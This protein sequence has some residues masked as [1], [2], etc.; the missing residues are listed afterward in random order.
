MPDG[1]IESSTSSQVSFVNRH[2][3]WC[4]VAGRRRCV[5]TGPDNPRRLVGL[6]RPHG[7]GGDRGTPNLWLPSETAAPRTDGEPENRL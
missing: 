7:T 4:S 5:Q 1:A 3:K 6:T 2:R